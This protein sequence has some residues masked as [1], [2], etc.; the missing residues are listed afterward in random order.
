QKP[1][2]KTSMPPLF[3]LL[4]TLSFPIVF[5]SVQSNTL[6]LPF[7]NPF[8]TNRLTLPLIL[9]PVFP[10]IIFAAVKPIANLPQSIV[11]VFA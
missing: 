9:I 2:N 8:G 1:L 3:T 5:N 4:I 10:T 11:V 6:T 7:Q